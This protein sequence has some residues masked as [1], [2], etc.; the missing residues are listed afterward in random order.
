MIPEPMSRLHRTLLALALL[1]FGSSAGAASLRLVAPADGATLRGGSVAEVRWSAGELPAHAEEWEAFLS[2]NGGG[3]YAFR[4]TPHL[5][6]DL[7]SFTF[8]VP[9]VDTRHARILI[10][11]GDEKRETEFEST[12]SFSIVRDAHADALL[13]PPLELGEGEAA[14]EGEA[15]VLSW[16]EGPRNG[17][18]VTQRTSPAAPSSSLRAVSLLA[19][20]ADADLTPP[21][22]HANAISVA[23]T[24]RAEDRSRARKP[25]TQPRAT[26]LLLACRRLNI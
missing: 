2:V 9:N 26:D 23:E 14:R 21:G 16:T 5:D 18:G 6:I 17:V 7:Q 20:D 1:A 22:H 3:Y 24:G 25:E 19:R 4:V 13:P 12:G 8:I 15:P 10:R 11:A